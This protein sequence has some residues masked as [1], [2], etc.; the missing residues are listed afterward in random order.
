MKSL[1]AIVFAFLFLVSCKDNINDPSKRNDQWVWWVDAH[2]GKARWIPVEGQGPVV[3]DGKFVFFYY[4]GKKYKT[5]HLRNG[6][7]VDTVFYYDL[8]GEKEGYDI[9][10][11]DT[12]RYYYKNGP[13]KTHYSNGLLEA[14]GII[15]N[16]TYTDQWKKYFRNGNI[17]FIRNSPN[18]TG[19]ANYYYETGKIKE[20]DT[21]INDV[22][23]TLKRWYATGQL[24]STIEFKN[25]NFNGRCMTYFESGKLKGE[26]YFVNGKREGKEVFYYENGKVNA[27]YNFKNNLLNGLQSIYYQNGKLKVEASTKDGE[28]D[29]EYKRY[30]ETGKITQRALFQEGTLIKQYF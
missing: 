21:V 3:K 12:V 29:G 9:Y 30:D 14:E 7:E 18:G 20:R 10:R 22:F 16:H 6:V 19:W 1:L 5:G 28:R 2:T 15:Q 4:N 13:V 27:I 17:S 26:G 25:G 11:K 24:E 23:F 8:K